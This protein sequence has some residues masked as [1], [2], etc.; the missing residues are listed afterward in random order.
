MK[1][2]YKV[3]VIAFMLIAISVKAQTTIITGTVI[4]SETKEPL[5]FV[6]VYLKGS[7]IGNVTDIN[8]NYSIHTSSTAYTEI[9]FSFLGYKTITRNIIVGQTQKIDVKLFSDATVLKEVEVVAG[10][11]RE[12]YRN[13]NNP[14]V[15][16][17]REM[18]EHKK[19][20][21]MEHYDFAEYEQY[22]KLQMSLSNLK[23]KF[24]QR[25]LFR[26]YKWLFENVDTTSIPGKTLLPIYL[27]ENLTD[28]YYQRS[29]KNKKS[30]VKAHQKVSFDDYVDNEGLSTYL[31]YLYNDIDIYDNNITILT[32]QFLS[33]IAD[34]APTFYK[35]YIT[36]T[37]KNENPVLVEL[38][39]APR[40]PADF[41]FQ[42]R[43]YVTL[44]GNYAVQRVNMAVNKSINLNW[45]REL[46]VEQ[47]FER[48]PDGKYHVIKSRMRA[49][50]GLSKSGGG[51]Y[52][53]RVVSYK[54]F[55]INYP[56]SEEFYK[57]EEKFSKDDLKN[58]SE[59]YWSANRHDT[60]SI[61]ESKV[62]QNIDS[63]QKMPSFRRTMD[64]AT[65]LLAGYKSFGWWELGPVNTFYSFNPVEG[66]RLRAGG[67]T[68]PKFNERL[69]F[70]TYGAYG[71]KDEKW[72]YFV[73][74]NYSFTGRSIREFPIRTLKVSFQRD[75]K[76]P[77]QELQFVQEDN[78]LL[79]FKRGVND[80]WL[81]NDI[82]N[83]DY[84][85]EFE[86][87]FSYRVG[88]KY[89]KQAP[90]GGL[91]FLLQGEDSLQ[92]VPRVNTAEVALELRWAPGEQFYQGKAYRVPI[93][94]RH[95]I[96]TA[97]FNG[98]I[99]GL[100][101]SQYNYQSVAL[102]VFKRF[103]LSQFGYTDVVVEGG[104]IFGTVPFPLLSIHR[105]NQ[106]YSYQL[107]SYN[108]MNF[109]E[110]VSD[111]YIS[112]NL[113]HYFNG[114]IF[115]KIPLLK[116]LKWRE[117]ATFKILYGSIRSENDPQ[118]NREVFAFP[119]DDAGRVTTFSLSKQPYMEAS[120]GIANI[121]KLLRFDVVKRLSYLDHP[122]VS[123]WGIRGR[124]KF[125]F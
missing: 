105:A 37:L 4:D 15:D 28:E 96:F 35:F 85:Q 74:A 25:K 91:E 44:D 102:N 104:H 98:G 29:P 94:N 75:T 12:R 14:A 5:P 87:H 124:F 7:T 19:Q 108:L 58:R 49:D 93:P 115:N 73:S 79:S 71:F 56:R 18:I 121:F 122:E 61:A 50:F 40:N 99:K 51:L 116:K 23:D 110:F 64:I 117:V 69:Y 36:D 1:Y 66:F 107:Q 34:G 100:F 17:V 22:E 20:N 59:E 95:P 13:K 55:V 32:N 2:L 47:N 103:Y 101:D 72:K 42:G 83:V 125:D 10:K 16:L 24:K 43:L 76:I 53:E 114:F 123:E 63:L 106:T 119:V 6:N 48:S 77:G 97:R 81:Y 45:V 67:R 57:Q 78:F 112:A 70:E 21:R 52:G 26:K 120:V 62:Y 46:N 86:N 39:F 118:K 113:D 8:G 88:L 92:P 11:G 27:Q 80:K 31:N 84:L 33:P 65:L 68:T 30:V 3:M 90:A 38:S 9:Q 82:W 109:L 60:L 89:W 41:L 111:Q 54:N